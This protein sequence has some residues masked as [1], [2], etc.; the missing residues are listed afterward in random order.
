MESWL[1]ESTLPLMVLVRATAE[2]VP[3]DG[4][5]PVEQG[6]ALVKGAIVSQHLPE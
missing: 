4:P 5:S 2:A 3:H 6:S 1:D